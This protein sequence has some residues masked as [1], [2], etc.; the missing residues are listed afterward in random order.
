MLT[1]LGFV[2]GSFLVALGIVEGKAPVD[3]FLNWQGLAI[4]AGGTIASTF[5]SYPLREVLLAF[6]S[7]LVIF[8][9]GSH[10]YVG[11]VNKMVQAIRT[12]QREGMEALQRDSEQ[13]K[14][15]WIFKDGVQMMAGGYSKEETREILEDQ[16][17]W[18]MSREMKQHQLFGAMARIA[19]GF[20]MIGTL[21]GLINMLLTLQSEPGKVGIGL[22]VAL[23]TTFYGLVLANIVFAPISEKIKERAE[24]NLLVETM[25]VEALLMIYDNR[26]YIYAR[27]KLS[28]YLNAGNRRKIA[29]ISP[30]GAMKKKAAR[31][32]LLAK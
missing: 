23:T 28:A 8:V 29:R 6:R 14:K 22:A 26:N 19:P 16:V 21:I 7:Y 32:R 24:N 3:V 2:T 17:R 31:S 1:F 10:D 12:F 13:M 11:A 15:L 18:Q 27:D 25:Q 5:V 4:V 30:N 9:A 20:G